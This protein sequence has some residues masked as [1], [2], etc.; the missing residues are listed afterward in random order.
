MTAKELKARMDAGTAPTILDVR[1][2][3]E[4]AESRIAGSILIP[5]GELPR[6]LD[7]LDRDREL[8]V[9]CKSGA[10]SARAVAMLRE[11]GYAKAVNLSGGILSW[12]SE[13][14]RS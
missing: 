5:L 8:V 10:R 13:I 9:H 14:G 12:L 3:S 6:R 4:A 1:E 7:E 2:R 11:K